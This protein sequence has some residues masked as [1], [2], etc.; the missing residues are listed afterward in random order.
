MSDENQ[1]MDLNKMLNDT[2]KEEKEKTKNKLD[3][4][5]I[6]KSTGK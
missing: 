5:I 3:K 2:P 1:E 4:K 6:Y